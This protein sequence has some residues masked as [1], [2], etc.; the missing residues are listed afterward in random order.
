MEVLT[1]LLAGLYAL[2][3]LAEKAYE[4]RDVRLLAPTMLALGAGFVLDRRRQA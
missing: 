3:L 1:I 2:Y 4:T